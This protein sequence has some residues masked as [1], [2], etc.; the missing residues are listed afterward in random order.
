MTTVVTHATVATNTRLQVSVESTSRR[1]SA[2]SRTV[3]SVI[4][5]EMNMTV[6][7]GMGNAPVKKM[8]TKP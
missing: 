4:E 1:A 8:M 6:A 5:V 3:F 2:I 7:M